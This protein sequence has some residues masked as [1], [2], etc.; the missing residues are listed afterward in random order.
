[1]KLTD[2]EII[3][4]LESSGV[5]ALANYP[6]IMLDND[7]DF[8]NHKK[9]LYILNIGHLKS[10]EW[11]PHIEYFDIKEAARRSGKGKLVAIKVYDQEKQY[12]IIGERFVNIGT[13][14]LELTLTEILSNKWYEVKE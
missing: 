6:A 9:G 1:M 3:K 11:E 7:G 4:H 8:M 13:V 14:G 2:P 10:N 5:V 12:D